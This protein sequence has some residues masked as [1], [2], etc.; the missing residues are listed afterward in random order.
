MERCDFCSSTTGPFFKGLLSALICEACL[1]D[2]FILYV[3]KIID[4][5]TFKN[6]R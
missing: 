1:K 5:M 6:T 3:E 4:N 2:I